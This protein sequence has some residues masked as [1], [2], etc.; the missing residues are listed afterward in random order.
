MSLS[1]IKKNGQVVTIIRLAESKA[2]IWVFFLVDS[3]F[4]N[5]LESI[6]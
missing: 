1:L 2:K 3:V 4:V 5:L 6:L